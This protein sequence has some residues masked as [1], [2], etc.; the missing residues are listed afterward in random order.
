MCSSLTRTLLDVAYICLRHFLFISR[1]IEERFVERA[2]V[3]MLLNCNVER[4]FKLTLKCDV[5]LLLFPLNVDTN[6]CAIPV[7]AV[8]L[9]LLT[10]L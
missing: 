8:I 5:C 2:A 6:N 7:K 4:V 9:E 3:A 1:R 10:I